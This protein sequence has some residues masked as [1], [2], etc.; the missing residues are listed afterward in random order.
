V[1]K[2]S[3]LKT[4]GPIICLHSGRRHHVDEVCGV[5]SA[6]LDLKYYTNTKTALF[7]LR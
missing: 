3:N 2:A 4:E 5:L 7:I 1:R 6:V